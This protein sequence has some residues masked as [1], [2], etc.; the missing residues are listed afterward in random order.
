MNNVSENRDNENRTDGIPIGPNSTVIP[1]EDRNTIES[2]RN[3]ESNGT[4][5][6]PIDPSRILV[7][8]TEACLV[9]YSIIVIISLVMVALVVIM[10]LIKKYF[11]KNDVN[12]IWTLL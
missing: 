5:T 7:P 12:S 2:L 9:L 1:A 10:A 3:L 11:T 6:S 4:R 8:I